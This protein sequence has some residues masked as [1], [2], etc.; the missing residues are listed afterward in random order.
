LRHRNWQ[1]FTNKLHIEQTTVCLQETET[2]TETERREE[3]RRDVKSDCM[4]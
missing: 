1:A 4:E 3:K 2:G